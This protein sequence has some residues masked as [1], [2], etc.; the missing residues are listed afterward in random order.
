MGR[1]SNWTESSRYLLWR[2]TRMRRTRFSGGRSTCSPRN[3]VRVL[4]L[5]KVSTTKNVSEC[6]SCR[7][8]PS[9]KKCPLLNPSKR[10]PVLVAVV[11]FWRSSQ[12]LSM[13][14]MTTMR[15]VY[16]LV[17]VV[18]VV[19]ISYASRNSLTLTLKTDSYFKT[20]SSQKRASHQLT[21]IAPFW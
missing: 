4:R 20:P 5:L 18:F 3:C 7:R 10:I 12:I 13:M 17:V 2:T 8:D 6:E 16:L 21:L 19:N 1:C 15:F 14:M 11:K 9:Y